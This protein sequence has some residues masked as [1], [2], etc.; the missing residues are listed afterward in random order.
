MLFYSNE[1]LAKTDEL[2]FEESKQ[3][4]NRCLIAITC[5]A[6]FELT[7]EALSKP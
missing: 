7:F 6:N 4:I 5:E 3:P 2:Y 1:G